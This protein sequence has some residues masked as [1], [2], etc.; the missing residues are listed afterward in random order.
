MVYTA[1]AYKNQIKVNVQLEAI[2]KTKKT[3]NINSCFKL[4]L[5]NI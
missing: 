3:L 4:T 5:K 1:Q 2:K